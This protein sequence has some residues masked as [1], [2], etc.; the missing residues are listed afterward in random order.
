[1][2]YLGTWRTARR[3][4]KGDDGEMTV[5]CSCLNV[6]VN[7]MLSCKEQYELKDTARF[8]ADAEHVLPT[9]HNAVRRKLQLRKKCALQQKPPCVRIWDVTVTQPWGT[10]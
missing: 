4:E 1:M 7:T 3:G 6:G 8:V 5:E 9:S 2:S 10:G